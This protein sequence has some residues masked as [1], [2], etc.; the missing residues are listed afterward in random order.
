MRKSGG[1]ESGGIGAAPAGAAA[2]KAGDSGGAPT[3]AKANEAAHAGRAPQA[4]RRRF[5]SGGVGGSGSPPAPSPSAN[6]SGHLDNDRLGVKQAEGA[7]AARGAGSLP[8]SAK[9]VGGES[10]DRHSDFLFASDPNGFSRG[11]LR[12]VVTALA[13]G[14]HVKLNHQVTQITSN[15]RGVRVECKAGRGKHRDSRTFSG[16]HALVTVPLGV[17]G[18]SNQVP[19]RAAQGEA[20]GRQPDGFGAVPEGC[21]CVPRNRFGRSRGVPIP[22]TL[23]PMPVSPTR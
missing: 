1:G 23:P 3:S 12:G 10:I 15:A 21:P 17:Q 2:P 5:G 14:A 11:R 4:E 16:S 20:G 8:V 22:S 13:G 19:S 9:P 18:G 6:T 7:E